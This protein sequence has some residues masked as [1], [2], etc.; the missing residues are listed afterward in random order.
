MAA[1]MNSFAVITLNPTSVKIEDNTA[2]KDHFSV[3]VYAPGNTGN[4]EAGFDIWPNKHSAIGSF[5]AADGTIKYTFCYVYKQMSSGSKTYIA[6]PNS[7]ISL[8]ITDLGNGKCKLSGSMQAAE[9]SGGTLYTYSFSETEFDYSEAP[10]PD[11]QPQDPFRF[12]PTEVTTINFQADVINF[13]ERT[14]YIEITLNEMA[15][16]KYDWVELRLLSDTLDMPAG[17]YTIDD[18]GKAGTLTASTGYLGGTKGDDPCHLA[19]R[20]E[21][22][23]DPTPY[24]LVSGSLTVSFNDKGDTIAISGE[25]K[26]H[27]GST[28]K[29]NARGYNMLYVVEE[30][31]REPENV[32]LAIDTVAITYRSDLSDSINHVYYYTFD[33]FSGLG[34]YPNVLL[35]VTMSKP[36]ALTEGTYT[37]EAKQLKGL[38][39][40]QNQTDFN[41]VFFGGEPYVFT[42]AWLKLSPADGDAWKYEM[43]I[44]DKI[45]SEYRFAFTQTP[46]IV[47]YPE[48]KEEIDPK[49][50]PFADEMRQQTIISVV[51]D[52]ALW[53]DETV[54]K[55]G[56]LDIYLTQRSAD[57]SGLRAYLH[58]GMYT[59]VSYPAAGTYPVNS[60]E[61]AGSFSASLGRYSS[62]L[63]PCYLSLMDENGWVYAVWYITGGNITL[64]YDE[65]NKPQ[66]YGECTTYFGS[67]IKFAYAD[68]LGVEEVPSDKIQSTKVLR[69]GQ[70]II[71]RDGK[72]YN[73]LGVTL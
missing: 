17:T 31:P 19:L 30:E 23:E 70:V 68:G 9:K 65:N 3:T 16:E 64:S 11:P 55:D 15:E 5:S 69:N 60:S 27:N 39:L 8:T 28:V 12:E 34:D 50:Q 66:L 33:F 52:T 21:W 4:Y 38:E 43:F 42:E 32:T 1:V 22:G 61:E 58:L 48:Q 24:Y 46:H 62:V 63:I 18:S 2:D 44:G 25:A 73:I 72:E 54:S 56:I 53:K 37:L 51:L 10:V 29:I 26:S 57:V 40:F 45:G 13:R 35:D 67:T 14:D 7:V 49:D 6:E 47:F 41:S 59:D 20:K 36:M 71:L